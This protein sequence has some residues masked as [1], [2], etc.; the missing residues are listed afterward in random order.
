MKLTAETMGNGPELVMVHGWGMNRA[1]WEPLLKILGRRFRTTLVDLPGHGNA[2]WDPHAAT[3]E[4][5]AEAVLDVVPP[6]AFWVGW[7]LG[8]LVMQQ[9]ALLAPGRVRALAGIATT[10]CFVRRR[11]WMPAVNER[12]LHQFAAQLEADC[13]ATLKRFL[14]L[15]FQGVE[16]GRELQ[17]TMSHLLA[18][19]PV[20]DPGALRTGLA[21]LQQS[22]LR[23]RMD[24]L[25]Q[26]GL[27]LL[28]SHDRLV[29][30][31]LGEH[32]HKLVPDHEVV[33]LPDAGHAPFL[34]HPQQVADHLGRFLEHD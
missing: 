16:N 28:G 12:L 21:L 31:G 32:L 24:H 10:P 25:H 23:H 6:H 5:W 4:K 11:D 13:G 22:D 14:A 26:P 15:Q 17:R 8:G 20:P 9:A 3:L 27:W 7:S 34:S 1:I 29:P 18:S 2:S 30:P 19:R 33:L